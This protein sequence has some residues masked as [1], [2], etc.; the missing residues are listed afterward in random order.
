[1]SGT[2]MLI[3]AD[4]QVHLQVERAC[5][6]LDASLVIVPSIENAFE[7][8]EGSMP[9]VVLIDVE[10]RKGGVISV[11]K[12]LRQRWQRLCAI[13]IAEQARSEQAIEAMKHG[14]VNY[15][16]K[17]INHTDL[18]THIENAMRISRDMTVPTVYESDQR[19]TP[20]E[21]I[22]GQSPAMQQ[23]FKLIG[24]IAPQNVNVLITGESG[25]G[26][27]LVAKALYHHSKRKDR[28]FLAVN[29][30]AIP[31][32]LLESELF[33]HEKGAF[34]G[35]HIRRIGKFE[36]C[37]GGTIFLDEIGDIPLTTQAKL[38][39]VLQDGSFQRLGGN[40]T[41]GCDVRII[42][43]TNQNIERLI[44]ERR[45]RKD[46]FYRLKVASIDMPPLRERDV[47]P[48]LLAHYFV[49]RFNTQLGTQIQKFSPLALTALL[50]YNWPGNVRELENIIK[51]SLVLARGTVFQLDFL[52]EKIRNVTRIEPGETAP[53]EMTTAHMS[54]GGN[55]QELCEQLLSHDQF[56]GQLYKQLVNVAE[57]ELIKACLRKA[58]GLIS[59]T[60]RMLGITRTTL[61]KK[62]TEHGIQINTLIYDRQNDDHS[63]Q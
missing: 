38:L 42:A 33:G 20:V 48:A 17:P 59:P 31:E 25:T 1:M 52:P 58:K 11:F 5:S 28:P 24:L 53:S 23:V 47:D 9:D 21:R 35:A 15:L 16:I 56:H 44:A 13:L 34:T 14:A 51:A 27:E 10:E 54:F 4:P 7:A 22:I 32:T 61:R 18:V 41:I 3:H 60:A 55:M 39:R 49:R 43:A 2:V 8:I 12:Q 46:L 37:D 6:E 63:G 57:C 30:A 40:E 19:D 62:M 36:Q 26:K 45:F 50:S 29:C